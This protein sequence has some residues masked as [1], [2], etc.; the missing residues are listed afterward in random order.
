[1]RKISLKKEVKI[2]IKH[3]HKIL[4]LILFLVVLQG[5]E[6]ENLK[7]KNIP[8]SGIEPI[9]IPLDLPEFEDG[10]GGLIAYDLNNDDQRD[11]LITQKNQI[12]VFDSTGK[13]LWD[14]KVDIHVTEKAE[15][16]GLPGLHAPGLQVADVDSDQKIEVLF[17][18]S[19]NKLHIVDGENGKS[20]K[21]VQLNVPKKVQRWE[22][23]VVVNFRGEGDKDLLLQATTNTNYRLGKHLAAYS[24][25]ELIKTEKP[26]P[27]WV[28]NDFHSPAHNGARVVDLDGDGKDEVI[29][30]NIVNSLGEI[31]FQL[32]I[33][34][35]NA[36]HIDSVFI[37]DVKPDSSGL[38][39][40]ALEEGGDNRIFLYNTK[41]LFWQADY[42]NQEPQNAAVGDFDLEKPGLE[43]WC[44]SRYKDQRPFVFDSTGKLIDIY[45]IENVA[46]KGWTTKG[47]EVI[48]PIHWT[49]EPKQLAAAKERHESGDVG[50]FKPLTGEFVDKFQT[51]ADRLYIADVTGDWR[52]ELVVMNH[53]ELRIYQNP[54]PNPRPDRPSL[55]ENEYYRRSKLTWNYYSP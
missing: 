24:I 5:C 10:S 27:L 50:L 35:Q 33:K 55:W 3:T 34:L 39:V 4:S 11:Y 12:S 32:P 2:L 54:A 44:R 19:D 49:G 7:S 40:V 28:Q 47:V 42:K 36:P 37:A 22:H 38:E 45:K 1:M 26:K 52:E 31:V 16:Q 53:Q 17:L 20:K 13:K 18:S 48:V 29:G 6:S 14:K 21:I 43:I 8:Y 15:A 23:L 46:P 25:E 30:G 41:E 51:V 9:R